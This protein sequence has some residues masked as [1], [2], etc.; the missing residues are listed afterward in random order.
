MGLYGGFVE[1]WSFVVQGEGVDSCTLI[2]SIYGVIWN[3][4]LALSGSIVFEL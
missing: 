4:D 3:V 1:L 2:G